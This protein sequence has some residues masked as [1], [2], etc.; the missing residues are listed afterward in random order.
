MRIWTAICLIAAL[1]AQPATPA[2]AAPASKT[3]EAGAVNPQ[4]LALGREIA[5]AFWPD[6][7]MQKMMSQM[8]GVQMG[9]MKGMFDKTP[10]DLG[11]KDAKEPDK[12]L[13]Q[14]IREE[15]PHF[16]ERAAITNRVMMEEIGKLMG[17]FE[18]Q[19]REALA[20]LYAKRFTLAELNDMATFFRTSSGKSFGAQLIPMMADP[21]YVSAMTEMMPRL[22][23]AMPAIAEK[24]KKA[25][26]HLPPPPKRK[27]KAD[28]AVVPTA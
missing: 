15:D 25:T 10:N 27:E 16:E 9:M 24:V 8:S 18:P 3:N 26:A 23:Q 4:R 17:N 20:R 28:A 13:G 11:I 1:A 19:M 6:G 22:M 2:A 7:T 5:N 12:T 14:L 21:D